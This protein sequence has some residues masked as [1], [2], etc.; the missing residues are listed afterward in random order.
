MP[1]TKR[2]LEENEENEEKAEPEVQPPGYEPSLAATEDLQPEGHG[3]PEHQP[4]VELRPGEGGEDRGVVRPHHPAE[5]EDDE[6]RPT[7]QLRTAYLELMLTQLMNINQK[8][9]KEIQ[10]T[11]MTKGEKEKFQA[12]IL[13]EI[14]T[15]LK[16][17]A[18]EFLDR[19][20]SE[21]IRIENQRRSSSQGVS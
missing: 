21:R 11:R 9:R 13:K 10:L 3:E 12:A 20:D 19:E 16:S 17:G 1:G 15:N 5:E 14:K 4:T 2:S 8:K 6:E 7:K 18:Y